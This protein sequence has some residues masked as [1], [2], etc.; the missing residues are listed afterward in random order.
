MRGK[1]RVFL[2]GKVVDCHSALVV[3]KGAVPSAL[4][5]R[6]KAEGGRRRHPNHLTVNDNLEGPCYASGWS[7]S[8]QNNFAHPQSSAV[9]MSCDGYHVRAHLHYWT[10]FTND[11][12]THTAYQQSHY[13]SSTPPSLLL[14]R[15]CLRLSSEWR[16]DQQVRGTSSRWA[17]L[18]Q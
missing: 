2:F 11:R 8:V 4:A 13:Q 3:K 10:T 6:L 5:G 1:N 16:Q 15:S 14:T 12:K 7:S 9:S 17:S 18:L